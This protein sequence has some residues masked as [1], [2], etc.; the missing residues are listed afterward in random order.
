M[1]GGREGGREGVGREK[2]CEREGDGKYGRFGR[3]RKEE[4]RESRN[5][6]KRRRERE[7]RKRERERERERERGHT[8]GRGRGIGYA[9]TSSPPSFAPRKS[10]LTET[11]VARAPHRAAH[12]C[13]ST[14]STAEEGK[15]V[16]Q[17]MQEFVN[18][19]DECV[20]GWRLARLMSGMVDDDQ[21]DKAS[22]SK[23]MVWRLTLHMSCESKITKVTVT[24]GS[25][26]D[27]MLFDGEDGDPF[28]SKGSSVGSS[29][30]V[31]ADGSSRDDDSA[32]SPSLDS[33]YSGGRVRSLARSREDDSASEATSEGSNGSSA[34][35]VFPITIPVNK[36]PYFLPLAKSGIRISD[37]IVDKTKFKKITDQ[38]AF[39]FREFVA[40]AEQSMTSDEKSP[41]KYSSTFTNSWGEEVEMLERDIGYTTQ[42]HTHCMCSC[43]CEQLFQS[44]ALEVESYVQYGSPMLT[45]DDNEGGTGALTRYQ[46][47]RGQKRIAS[48]KSSDT[49]GSAASAFKNMVNV[50]I[51]GKNKR[52]ILYDRRSKSPMGYSRH[53][54]YYREI[55]LP[56]PLQARD[57][58][59]MYSGMLKKR[60]VEEG[61]D[62]FCEYGASVA[63]GPFAKPRKGFVRAR[64]GPNGTVGLTAVGVEGVAQVSKTD[65]HQMFAM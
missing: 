22:D 25:A 24:Q 55:T 40:L 21:H 15:S 43:S 7:S 57:M 46:S 30:L 61:G 47:S 56:W 65:V 13:D 5:R 32:E 4:E 3:E 1:E 31:S 50:K 54:L 41:W 10:T 64:V 20:P 36:V 19:V 63:F 42:Y 18:T 39:Y 53:V 14:S 33:P 28:G 23:I 49:G 29:A 44:Q 6:E 16:D 12:C 9:R 51:K 62:M 2:K 27:A 45:N 8:E 48:A 59:Y 37:L 17:A 26:N 52:R 35:M 60:P 34:A 58:P 38:D 11:L